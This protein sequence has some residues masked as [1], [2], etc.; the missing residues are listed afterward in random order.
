MSDSDQLPPPARAVQGRRPGWSSAAARGDADGRLCVVFIYLGTAQAFVGFV[1]G[2]AQSC[3]A[4]GD[5]R[6]SFVVAEGS[7]LCA[8]LKELGVATIGV[9]GVDHSRPLGIVE[10]YPQARRMLLAY[11]DRERPDLVVSLMPHI[12]SPLMARAVRKRC[13]AYAT[14][15]HDAVPHPGDRSAWASR[16]LL[17]EGRLADGVVTLSDT[18]A[19]ALVR[20]RI[21]PPDR[22]VRLFHPDLLPAE[23][24]AARRTPHQPP[25]LLFFGRILPYKGLPLLVA[26]VEYLRD[27]GVAIQLGV[28]G[29]G[30]LEALRPRLDALDAEVINRTLSDQEVAGLLARYDAM[31][32]SHIEASQS[33]VAALAFGSA[34]P[35]VSTPIGGLAEQVV[36]GRTGVL[37]AAVTAPAFADAIQ[38][39]F[40]AP[41]LY[42]EICAH[43]S[44]TRDDRSMT[45]F[46]RDVIAPFTPAE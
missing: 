9:P 18:V 17:W 40:G 1:R 3:P 22:V 7:P 37:A 11:L 13:G 23:R 46:L 26:A 44:A 45:R 38:E 24:P 41:G 29:A 43:L 35:V 2:V 12:W 31:A 36:P 6:C 28:A 14:I 27:R 34:M 4:L 33:G 32:C 8:D 20:K 5:V 15:I 19:D 25:R 30:D 16:W 10:R 39:L 21:K 42:D